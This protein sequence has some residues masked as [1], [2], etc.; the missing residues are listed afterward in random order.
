M[1]GALAVMRART[2]EWRWAPTPVLKLAPM[3]FVGDV[4][5]SIYLWHWPLLLLAP[6]VTHRAVHTDT[7]I[8]VLMLTIL[9][10]WLTKVIVEDPVRS[11]RFLTLRPPRV[12]FAFAAAA[13]ALVVAVT[14]DGNAQVRAQTRKAQRR[15]DAI[16]AKKPSCFGAASRDPQH[17]CTNPRLRFTVVP[18]PLEAKQ[19]GPHCRVA[20]HIERKQVCRF[21][22][23]K[24]KAKGTVA[25]IGDSHAGHWRPALDIVARQTAGTG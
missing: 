18:T 22:V 8:T 7:R 23:A 20:F 11:G 2:S 4:S 5:Y 9:A 3:Q 13:I 21:G 25:L 10:A 19:P 1:A 15:S 12:T 24:S 17:P 16:L 6:F 14:V